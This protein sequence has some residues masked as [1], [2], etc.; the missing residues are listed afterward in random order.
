M[1]SRSWPRGTFIIS[2][3]YLFYIFPTQS[4][5]LWDIRSPA[6][7]VPTELRLGSIGDL[8]SLPVQRSFRSSHTRPRAYG[9]RSDSGTTHARVQRSFRLGH[10]H[11][12][13]RSFRSRPSF[14]A[15]EQRKSKALVASLRRQLALIP[16]Y[17]E[18]ERDGRQS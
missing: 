2:S 15:G 3:I 17:P 4:I 11:T 7:V 16:Q 14:T 9:S 8:Q 10:I 6:I 13:Q 5:C 1:I 12:R 18:Q